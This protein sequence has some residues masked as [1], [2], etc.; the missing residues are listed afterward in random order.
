MVSILKGKREW[1]AGSSFSDRSNVRRR[2]KDWV[3]SSR[4]VE[5][6]RVGGRGRIAFLT[7][8]P[9]NGRPHFIFQNLQGSRIFR[10]F[11]VAE[12]IPPCALAPTGGVLLGAIVKIGRIRYAVL[13]SFRRSLS[14]TRPVFGATNRN[15]VHVRTAAGKC[16]NGSG[17]LVRPTFEGSGRRLE[18]LACAIFSQRHPSDLGSLSE[19][20][21]HGR[22]D[23]LTDSCGRS[24]PHQRETVPDA[25]ARPS[26]QHAC[27]ERIGEA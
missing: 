18:S 16:N 23:E 5:P 22:R 14:S 10:A 2:R 15:F 20:A 4:L 17:R 25:G 13:G 24:S 21:V 11:L 19:A 7:A 27:Y 3:E 26:N 12:K 9:I 1:L 8:L 6:G